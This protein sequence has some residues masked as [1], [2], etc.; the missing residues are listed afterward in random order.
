MYEFVRRVRPRAACRTRG[1]SASDRRHGH[2]PP[3]GSVIVKLTGTAST[4]SL[5]CRVGGL[6]I[7]SLT[8]LSPGCA[9]RRSRAC[10]GPPW[11]RW[12]SPWVT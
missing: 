7:R 5:P 10:T 6:Q 8:C 4:Y 2:P 3:G 1:M 12:T 11:T 9:S